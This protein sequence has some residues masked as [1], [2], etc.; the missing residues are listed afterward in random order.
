VAFGP[1]LHDED[2]YFLI[3]SYKDLQNLQQSEDAFY[4]S[5]EWKKGPR[6]AILSLILNYT[7]VVLPA[8]TAIGL[9]NKI[10]EMKNE[11]SE[12]AD[13]AELSILNGRFIKNFLDQDVASHRKIIHED[14][15]CIESDGKIVQRDE[16]L[17]NWATDFANSDY[18][19]FSYKDEFIRIFGNMA[20]VRAKTVYTKKIDGRS[21]EGYTIYT[22]TYVKENGRWQCVQVQITPVKNNSIK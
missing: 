8:D 18:T 13:S 21:V 7:T 14:F 22:D 15:V 3:R 17:K 19:S 20:L 12:K 5:E 6:E 16:Y 9:S 11:L 1:S 10:T 4:S 2:S